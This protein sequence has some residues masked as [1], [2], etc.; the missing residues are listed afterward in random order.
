MPSPQL[1][2]TSTP[3]STVVNALEFEPLVTYSRQ[4]S[5]R[6]N[7]QQR[8][9]V[10]FRERRGTSSASWS[11]A[12]ATSSPITFCGAMKQRNADPLASFQP[13]NMDEWIITPF[14]LLA[15]WRLHLTSLAAD[16]YC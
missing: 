14:F 3:C 13:S 1:S 8:A 15:G 9:A 4:F 7:H 11:A 2:K 16:G 10:P 5:G 12:L 6:H